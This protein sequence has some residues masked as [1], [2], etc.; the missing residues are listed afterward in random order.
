[1]H[2]TDWDGNLNLLLFISVFQKIHGHAVID[3]LLHFTCTCGHTRLMSVIFFA[4]LVTAFKVF[5]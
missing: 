4:N 2:L 5:L 3:L 1:M